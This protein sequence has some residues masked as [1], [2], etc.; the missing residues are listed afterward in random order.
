MDHGQS[1]PVSGTDNSE[2]QN[3]SCREVREAGG[4]S[5]EVRPNLA[6]GNSRYLL[7]VWFLVKR[8]RSNQSCSGGE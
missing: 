2:P 1:E 6:A 8:V 3:R 4:I 7:A 5:G